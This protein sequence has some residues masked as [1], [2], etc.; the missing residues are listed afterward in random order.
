MNRAEGNG[1]GDVVCDGVGAVVG[2][3]E[4]WSVPVVGKRVEEGASDGTV[5]GTADGA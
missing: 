4:G 3:K 2:I 5:E 1:V